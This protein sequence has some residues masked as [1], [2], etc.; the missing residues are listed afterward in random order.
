MEPGPIR[1]IEPDGTSEEWI[2]DGLDEAWEYVER[3]M[4]GQGAPR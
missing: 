1:R 3:K 4:E 2:F